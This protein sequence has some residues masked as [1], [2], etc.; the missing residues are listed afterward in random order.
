MYKEALEQWVLV[1][2]S[3]EQA[4]ERQIRL[5]Q[6]EKVLFRKEEKPYTKKSV[7]YPTKRVRNS[8]CNNRETWAK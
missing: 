8:R 4:R 5:Q 3:S 1:V 2:D 6:P 7:Y